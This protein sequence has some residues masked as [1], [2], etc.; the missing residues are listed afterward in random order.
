MITDD[1]R[2]EMLKV[3]TAAYW[4]AKTP[5]EE[6]LAYVLMRMLGAPCGYSDIAR[7]NPDSTRSV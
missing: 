1:E 7:L 6:Q 2:A 3:A 4:R 5:V